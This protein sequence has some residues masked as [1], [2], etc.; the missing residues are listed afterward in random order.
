VHKFKESQFTWSVFIC[1][2]AAA[3]P[4]LVFDSTILCTGKFENIF[5]FLRKESILKSKFF[6][7]YLIDFAEILVQSLKPSEAD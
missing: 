1:V 4:R 3:R 6:N 7:C 5:M 2:P